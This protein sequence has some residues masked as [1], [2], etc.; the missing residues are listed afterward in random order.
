MTFAAILLIWGAFVIV[1]SNQPISSNNAS[2][3]NTTSR[4]ADEHI[5]DCFELMNHAVFDNACLLHDACYFAFSNYHHRVIYMNSTRHAA[6]HP[7]NKMWKAL[8]HDHSDYTSADLAAGI[9]CV[10]RSYGVLSNHTVD[11]LAAMPGLAGHCDRWINEQPRCMG[12][13]GQPKNVFVCND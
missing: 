10:E 2:S 6:T 8:R 3:S 7:C 9:K 11:D 1:V 12:N 13:D 5:L 4:S